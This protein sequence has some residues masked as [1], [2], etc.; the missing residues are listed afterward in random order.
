MH[1]QISLEE[2]VDDLILTLGTL[3][4]EEL[5]PAVSS[6]LPLMCLKS[7]PIHVRI[8]G[9]MP[10]ACVLHASVPVT[11]NPCR[12]VT[13]PKHPS[14]PLHRSSSP[15]YPPYTPDS[16]CSIRSVP[17]SS[18]L[19]SVQGYLAHKKTPL[20]PY[21]RP[22]PRVLWGVPEGGMFSYGQGTPVHA[23]H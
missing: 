4:A 8:P 19:Q 5:L 10:G 9:R 7:T 11:C 14:S 22:V 20:G 12:A 1:V 15:R 21:R 2:Y 16:S 23:F 17:K 3:R 13:L 6:Q 18:S